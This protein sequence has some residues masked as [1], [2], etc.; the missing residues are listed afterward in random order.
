[1]LTTVLLT[2]PTIVL[3]VLLSS[4]TRDCRFERMG[5]PVADESA[6]AR[7]EVAVNE[8]VDLHR[9]LERA[10]P[11]M[12]FLSDPEQAEMAAAEFRAVLRD[13]RPQ[14]IQGAFFTSEVASVFRFRVADAM[15]QQHFNVKVMTSPLDETEAERWNSNTG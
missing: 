6:I 2:I 15:R 12:W 7:F 13:A 14:A 1:M 3:P 5:D 10:W 4:P 11:P 8:Y 9:R